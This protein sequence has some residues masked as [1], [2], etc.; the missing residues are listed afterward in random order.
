MLGS[1]PRPDTRVRR[2][3]CAALAVAAVL[4]V[5]GC[6][7]FDSALG[8][9]WIDVQFT[10]NTTMATARHVTS[11]CSRLPHVRVQSLTPDVAITGMADSV[12]YNVSHASDADMA[13][14]QECLERFPADIAG[15]TLSDAGGY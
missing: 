13:R 4:A 3:A 10:A 7:K 15:Y 11:Q 9:Q 14:L 8:Q 6:A 12:R 2:A 5:G 1:V